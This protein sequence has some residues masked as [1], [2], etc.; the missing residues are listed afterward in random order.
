MLL[1]LHDIFVFVLKSLGS[2]Q[3]VGK[4]CVRVAL[5]ML[6][7]PNWQPLE[8]ADNLSSTCVVT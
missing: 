4:N 7:T 1:H 6:A 8:G 3:F 2:S 5:A